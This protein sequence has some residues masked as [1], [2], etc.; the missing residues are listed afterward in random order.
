MDQHR[1]GVDELLD[2]ERLQATDEI[3]AAIDVD[4][5]VLRLVLAAEV[6]EGRQVHDARDA[7]AIFGTD[8]VEGFGHALAVGKVHLND[9]I[10][11]I[12]ANHIEA[13][14]RVVLPQCSR[15]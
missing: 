1:A 9:G 5:L 15:E 2:V 8:M 4:R 13:D 3:A 7:A 12:A 11:G 14:D 6:E 10:I